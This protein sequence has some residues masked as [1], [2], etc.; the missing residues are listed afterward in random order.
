[1]ARKNAVENVRKQERPVKKAAVSQ[2]DLV[3]GYLVDKGRKGATNF[4]MMMALHI[5]DVR[6]RITDLNRTFI[7]GYWIDSEYEE[8]ADGK[9]YKRYWA[10]PDEYSSLWEF[11][12][13]AKHT[14]TSASKRTGGGRR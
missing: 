6:K 1:M 9:R 2:A 10:I 4:E 7:D 5:C 14:R 3:L 8:S 12:N 13:E 11:L